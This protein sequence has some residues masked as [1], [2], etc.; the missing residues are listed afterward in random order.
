MDEQSKMCNAKK[1]KVLVLGQRKTRRANRAFFSLPRACFLFLVNF[2]QRKQR[3]SIYSRKVRTKEHIYVSSLTSSL[4]TS[5]ELVYI[6]KKKPYIRK[7][8]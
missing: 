2:R 4:Y 5:I 1:K 8:L 3:T 6:P 7:R